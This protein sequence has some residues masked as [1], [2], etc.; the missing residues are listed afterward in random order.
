[1]SSR[2]IARCLDGR[3]LKGIGL[4]VDPGRPTFHIRPSE[5]KPIEVRLDELK[6][7]FFV[8]TLEGNRDHLEALSPVADDSRAR[9]AT[10]VSMRFHDG[11]VMVGMM[12]SYPPTR[13]YFFIVPVDPTSNNIRILVNRNAV[14]AIEALSGPE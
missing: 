7:L 14:V 11:E 8:R 3:L 1:M 10:I 13:P 4:N 12:I 5:S 2:V 6:A 9:G